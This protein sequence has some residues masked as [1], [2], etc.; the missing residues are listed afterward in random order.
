MR[1]ADQSIDTSVAV[2]LPRRRYCAKLSAIKARSKFKPV[3]GSLGSPRGLLLK[4]EPRPKLAGNGALFGPEVSL[5]HRPTSRT[6][7]CLVLACN[8]TKV[9]NVSSNPVT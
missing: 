1:E 7:V 9:H 8:A 4:I 3:I 6:I 2:W 5:E